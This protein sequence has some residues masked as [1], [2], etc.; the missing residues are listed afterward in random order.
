MTPH[1]STQLLIVCVPM[2]KM[3]K[4]LA[5]TPRGHIIA[6]L[7]MKKSWRLLLHHLTYLIH[8][9]LIALTLNV[10]QTLLL[11][12]VVLPPTTPIT[13]CLWLKQIACWMPLRFCKSLLE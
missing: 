9:D 5:V 13:T 10:T 3:C 1:D 8:L 11:Y 7:G 2:A 6:S 12:L 4:Y